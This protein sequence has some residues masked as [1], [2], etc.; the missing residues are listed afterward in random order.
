MSSKPY[1]LTKCK[2]TRDE[3][4]TLRDTY[5]LKWS[6]ILEIPKYSLIPLQTLSMI[7]LGKR[8]VPKKYRKQLGEPLLI[9]TAACIEC[10]IVHVGKCPKPKPWKQPKKYRLGYAWIFEQLTEDWR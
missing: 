9:S 4:R 8:N 2:G 5:G 10:G 1:D 7:Y 3:L 6:Q